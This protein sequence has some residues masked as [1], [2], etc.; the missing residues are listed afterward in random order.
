[1][2]CALDPPSAP[3]RLLIVEDE[4]LVALDLEERLGKLGYDVVGVVDNGAD[5]LIRAGEGNTDLV[6]MDIHIHGGMDG[7]Q[8][9]AVLRK[10]V[11]I[12]VVFLTAHADEATLQRAGLTEPF[13]Y[14]LKPFDER[15]LRATIQM[16]HYRCRAEGRLRKMERWLSTTLRSIGDGVIATD[17]EGRVTYLN[18]MAET[19]TG[20]TRADALGLQLSKVFSISSQDGCDET[21]DILRRAMTAGAVVALAEGCFL[22]RRDGSLVPVSDSFA[23]IR[24]DDGTITGFVVIFRD[25]TA[26]LEA[27]NERRRLEAK[28]QEAQRLE[29][30]GVLASGIAHDFNNLLVAVTCN[31]S[32]GRTMVPEHSPLVPRLKDIEDAAARAA[33]LCRQMLAYA[34][35]SHLAL[36]EVELS[37]FTRETSQ[38]FQVAL[39]KNTSLIM[40][41]A[42]G[43]PSTR[44]DHSQLQ[45]VIMNLVIN[46][47]EALGGQPGTVLVQTRLFEAS[48]AFVASCR[49]GGDA[50]PGTYLML[51]VTDSGHGMSEE[52]MSR[53]FDPFFTTK[54]TGRGL[55]LAAISGIVRSHGGALAVEST[56]GKGT[57]FRVL[58]PP[59]EAPESPPPPPLDFSWRSTGRALLVDDDMTIR[60]AGGSV[61]EH[62]GFEVDTA[63]DGLQA[64]QKA[65]APDADYRF[66][67][68]D[69]TMPNMDGPSAF[70]LIREKLPF[71]PIL[72]MSGYSDQQVQNLFEAGGPVAFLEKPFTISGLVT[73]LRPLL[74]S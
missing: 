17:A 10:T 55:G 29:S 36:Q 33:L 25:D 19:V 34:G 14:V 12:P 54:F 24:D 40:D 44:A 50:A 45:Q 56:P 15:E 73:R 47:S 8:T 68:I 13:G 18:A 30:L 26:H 9:A 48:A 22:R 27:E 72:F 59:T 65:T 42:A 31:A 6:L 21:S 69:L 53:I 60:L 49:V 58:F 7:I 52:V 1:M 64:V 63:N 41:L 71:L 23:P 43:L 51:E 4:S 61:L 74:E 5:A 32:L 57:A 11:E 16:A 37:K 67:L 2:P 39:H 28:M 46:G 35:K 66:M 3:L 20:W 70:R 38:L 62:L